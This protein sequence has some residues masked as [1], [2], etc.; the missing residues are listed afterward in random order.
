MTLLEEHSLQTERLP[1]QNPHTIPYSSPSPPPEDTS[2]EPPENSQNLAQQPAEA[3]APEKVPNAVAA[4]HRVTQARRELRPLTIAYV[5]DSANVLHDMLVTY[6]RLGHK[7]QIAS[8]PDPRY[9]APTAVWDKVVE[10]ECDRNIEWT[11]DPRE[12][13]KGADVVVTDTWISMG[14]E[15]EYEQRV[16]DFQ[17]YQVTEEMCEGAKRGWKFLHCLPR[18]SHEVNDEVCFPNRS[19]PQV[20]NLTNDLL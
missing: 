20:V 10:L 18:K 11:A 15:A 9:R 7:L 16:K 19:F 3:S 14:Q 13:V 12:A 4:E 17:G 6:P 5:G 8:P 1:A 2:Q